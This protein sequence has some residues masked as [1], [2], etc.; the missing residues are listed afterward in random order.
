MLGIMR[1]VSDAAFAP[2]GFRR[3][4]RIS[5]VMFEYF[6]QELAEEVC[7]LCATPRDNRSLRSYWATPHQL[8]GFRGVSKKLTV[9]FAHP[10]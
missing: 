6:A 9:R 2:E 5:V 1:A 10:N 7:A 3:Q 8:P 4:F